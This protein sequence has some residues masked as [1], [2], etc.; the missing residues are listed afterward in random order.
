MSKNNWFVPYYG[1]KYRESAKTIESGLTGID[2]SSV[3]YIVEPFCG[4][5]GFSRYVFHNIKDY[6]GKFV[7][8]DMDEGLINFYKLVKDGKFPELFAKMKQVSSALTDKDKF[9]AYRKT[10]DPTTGEGYYILK[11]VRGSYRE[12]LFNEGDINRLKNMKIDNLTDLIELIKSERVEV[13]NQSSADTCKLIESLIDKYGDKS[14]LIYCDP[15]Y[16]Q[17][18]NS[19][20]VSSVDSSA[21]QS[22]ESGTNLLKC[23]DQSVIYIEILNLLRDKRTITLSVLNHTCLM[24]E[25]FKEHIALIYDKRYSQAHHNR[26]TGEIYRKYTKHMIISNF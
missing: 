22:K 10:L 13:Y 11:R 20:Y 7:W 15:P 3:K 25:L 5:A 17:S 1:N 19:Y 14:V 26:L 9:K 16:F 24:G 6:T 21:E 8:C 4:S 23:P 18:C 2:W 12:D